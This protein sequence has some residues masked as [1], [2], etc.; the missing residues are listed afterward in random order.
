LTSK[1]R[2]VSFGVGVIGREV[3]RHIIKKQ[4]WIELVGA[5]DNDPKKVGR[6]LGDVV[7]LGKELGITIS[8]D[9]KALFSD[10]KVDVVIHTTS[11]HFA[12]VCPQLEGIVGYGVDVVSS[13]EEL[14]YPYVIDE[15]LANK[16]HLLA[17]QHG[18][19]ILGTGINPGFVMDALPIVLTAPCLD[20]DRIKV[21]RRMNAGSRR[22]PFQRKIGA[23]MSA[24]EFK[25]AIETQRITGHVGLQES[26]AMI[27]AAL[28]WKLDRIETGDVEPILLNRTV[29][30][31]W[32]TIEPGTVAGSRQTAIGVIRS[33]PRI[34][35]E[36]IAFIGSEEEYD[37][38]EIDGV[39]PIRMKISPCVHG[40]YGTIG[41]LINMIPRVANAAPGLVTMKDLPLPVAASS[42]YANVTGTID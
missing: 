40:D 1:I 13:C 33:Q 6:D 15:K 34:E 12:E 16:L 35:L 23:G 24:Q 7:G 37:A 22:I 26:I 2:V 25:E 28:G 11:S 42:W 21:T 17:K 41:M 4:T 20:V 9:P 3:V 27:S 36:F 8:N 39:P 10:T 19:T 5:L 14:S 29:K 30:S 38:V 32:T 31:D 18:A